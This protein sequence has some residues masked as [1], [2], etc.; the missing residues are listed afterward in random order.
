MKN[1]LNGKKI[2]GRAGIAGRFNS[3]EREDATIA[4]LI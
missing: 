3:E 2:I 4:K 1:G